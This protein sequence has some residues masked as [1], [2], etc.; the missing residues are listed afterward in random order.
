MANALLEDAKT[1]RSKCATTGAEIAQGT[2]RVGF[3]I[4]RTGRRCMTYQ[5]PRAFLDGLGVDV[6]QDNRSRCKYSGTAISK[7]DPLV[8]LTVGGAKE[9]KP[10]SQVCSLN[11]TSTFISNVILKVGGKFQVQKAKGFKTLPQD[12][13]AKVTK[14]LAGSRGVGSSS[15][16]AKKRPASSSIGAGPV[17]AK[18]VRK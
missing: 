5:T 16:A 3:E 11:Q 10:T 1:G 17:T 13:Q 14:A 7:G 15:Q 2:P 4:W 12:I 6:A 9:E 18:R 8:V